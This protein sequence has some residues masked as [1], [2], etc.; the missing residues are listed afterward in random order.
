MAQVGRQESGLGQQ[1]IQAVA[2]GQVVRV[3]AGQ[4]VAALPVCTALVPQG[5]HHLPIQAAQG[6]RVT[7]VVVG[8]AE[9]EEPGRALLGTRA[10]RVLNTQPLPQVELL[11]QVA[12]A[13]VVSG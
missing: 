1:N 12:A 6:E 2:A 11:V 10:I 5:F 8:R 7:L 13:V 9:R 4:A 3:M